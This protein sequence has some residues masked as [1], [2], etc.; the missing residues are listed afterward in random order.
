MRSVQA[1]GAWIHLQQLLRSE[2]RRLPKKAASLSSE[3]SI[4]SADSEQ[5][6]DEVSPG[7]G[8]LDPPPA[9]VTFRVEEASDGPPPGDGV[10]ARESSPTDPLFVDEVSGGGS[11]SS[12]EVQD[13][14]RWEEVTRAR[15]EQEL[16]LSALARKRTLAAQ[17]AT[18][19]ELRAAREA[20]TFGYS[21]N[22]VVGS[23][24]GPPGSG[25]DGG[26]AGPTSLFG[27]ASV[28]GRTQ[29][30]FLLSPDMFY[31]SEQCWLMPLMLFCSYAV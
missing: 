13:R 29:C 9:T 7:P 1:L 14:R 15:I 27:S 17:E 31:T 12:E 28:G 30:S 25:G 23:G 20:R 4:S 24:P 21:G 18:I 8:G 22:L 2:W 10:R 19:R 5:E 6:V 16:P 11:R 3:L 26:P